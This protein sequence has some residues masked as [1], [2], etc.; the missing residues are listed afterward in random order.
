MAVRIEERLEHEADEKN[1]AGDKR[2]AWIG[3]AW[4]RIRGKE[5]RSSWRHSE[6]SKLLSR[7]FGPVHDVRQ[8][9]VSRS[10]LQVAK[11]DRDHVVIR[12]GRQW[13][14]M[15]KSEYTNLIKASRQEA[16]REAKEARDAASKERMEAKF[17]EQQERDMRRMERE[18][19]SDVVAI[20]K[21][22]GGIRPSV[23]HQGTK[24]DR[25]EYD[26]LP[27]T[28][29]SSAG[30]LTMDDAARNINAQMPWLHIDTIDDLVQY[31]DRHRTHGYTLHKA[32]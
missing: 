17:R 26:T 4:N 6:E 7:Y 8:R 12:Q 23:S 31:F 27:S 19:Y 22:S 24:Y 1:L 5:H 13:F 32:S 10:G 25:G 15:P 18:Q 2:K 14:D 16:K 3:G 28:V 21:H 9:A 20:I 29:R 30:R 11:R